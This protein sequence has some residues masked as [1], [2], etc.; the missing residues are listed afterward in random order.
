MATY[1]AQITVKFD[2]GNDAAA[3]KAKAAVASFLT[4]AKL[5]MAALA[6]GL[7]VSVHS[8]TIAEPKQVK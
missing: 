7:N 1:E 5:K 8:V 6:G 4:P 3:A 2:A